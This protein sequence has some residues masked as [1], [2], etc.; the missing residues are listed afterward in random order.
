VVEKPLLY[1]IKLADCFEERKPRV[2]DASCGDVWTS[3]IASARRFFGTSW[4]EAET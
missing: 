1:R 2:N 3:V 4:S